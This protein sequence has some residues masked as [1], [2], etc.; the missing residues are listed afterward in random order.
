MLLDKNGFCGG[1]VWGKF[2][3]SNSQDT[4]LV[5]CAA[6]VFSRSL[7]NGPRLGKR[8]IS[9][10]PTFFPCGGL[11]RN[12]QSGTLQR[13]VKVFVA[14]TWSNQS[15]IVSCFCF[16]YFCCWVCFC[17]LESISREAILDI[18][19]IKVKASEDFQMKK[20]LEAYFKRH[21]FSRNHE[22]PEMGQT[23]DSSKFGSSVRVFVES[24]T[25]KRYS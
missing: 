8:R 9:H 11:V 4:R 20:L 19:N 13:Y 16:V 10:G 22:K 24:P 23:E 3:N 17:L 15:Y 7:W 12:S 25:L 2:V 21:T 14:Q 6:I 18:L 1:L 5:L